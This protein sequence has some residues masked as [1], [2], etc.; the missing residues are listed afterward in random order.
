M[1]NLPEYMQS[2][3]KHPAV[4]QLASSPLASNL[5]H[6]HETYLEP[7]VAYLREAYLDPSLANLRTTYLD[8]YLVQPLAHMLASMPDLATVLVLL[9]V[10]FVSL[11]VLDYTRRVVMFWVWLATRAVYWGTIIALGVYVYNAGFEKVARDVGFVFNFLV[12]LLE[13]FGHGL[14]NSTAA[15]AGNAPSHGYGRRN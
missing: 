1:D 4:Q 5:G 2:V 11:K 8:P 9:F 12:G 3:L 10:L 14:E 7:S 13:Q 15:R 6:L